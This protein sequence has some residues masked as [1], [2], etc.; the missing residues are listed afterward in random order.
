[1]Y[2]AGYV[3]KKMTHS[4]DPR[5]DGRDREF[6]RMSLRPGLGAVALAPVVLAL[7]QHGLPVPLGLRHEKKIM[8]LGRYLR[9][10]IARKISDGTAEGIQKA[11][12]IP[13]FLAQQK[14]AVSV[15]R[16]Y[17]WSLEIRPVDVLHQITPKFNEIPGKE[18]TL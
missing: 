14:Y 7:V 2:I 1:M 15:L 10:E 5:L 18:K 8:P 12:Q 3:V 13:N 16:E 17:A 11:L 4:L 9:R 6:A